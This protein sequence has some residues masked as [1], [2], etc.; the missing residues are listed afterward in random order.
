M[1]RETIRDGSNPD[2]VIDLL[3]DLKR[4]SQHEYCMRVIE[5]T[6]EISEIFKL[7]E[8]DIYLLGG[9]EKKKS[10]QK[11]DNLKRDLASKSNY[12]I[13]PYREAI[14]SLFELQKNKPLDR[15]KMVDEAKFDH[16]NFNQFRQRHRNELLGIEDEVVEIDPKHKK[17][18][19]DCKNFTYSVNNFHKGIKEIRSHTISTG[20]INSKA[21]TL[22]QQIDSILTYTKSKSFRIKGMTNSIDKNKKEKVFKLPPS[23]TKSLYQSTAELDPKIKM[24]KVR[25]SV[26][27]FEKTYEHSI[28]QN[29][30]LQNKQ[31]IGSST[32]ERSYVSDREL[33]SSFWYQ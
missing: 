14:D 7:I 10:F 32:K 19:Y 24:T 20:N 11:F 33:K 2:I 17:R 30:K 22:S 18:K 3:K 21:S 28:S 1:T 6:N 29:L 5:L 15:T 27:E 16:T 4:R 26:G 31:L 9:G 12:F 13:K 25:K 8:K 23:Q